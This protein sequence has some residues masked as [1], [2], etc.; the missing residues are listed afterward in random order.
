[1][2]DVTALNATDNDIKQNR[3]TRVYFLKTDYKNKLNNKEREGKLLTF[4]SKNIDRTK[5][6]NFYKN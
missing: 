5:R 3:S 2:S 1:M 6:H 4:F